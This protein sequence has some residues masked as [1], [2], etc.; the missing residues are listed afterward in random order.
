MESGKHVY[1]EKPLATS[2]AEARKVLEKAKEKNLLIGC[3]PDTFL[4]GG[5]QTCRKIIDDGL[6]GKPI[7]AVAFMAN[8]GHESWHPDPEFYYKRG[9]GPLLDMGPYYL[10]A[11][12]NLIGP[13]KK[14]SA[15]SRIFFPQRTITSKAKYGTTIK[16]ETPTHLAGTIDFSSGAI[17]TII[18]SF[19]VWKDNLPPIEIYGTK[20]SLC[21]TDPNG[22]GG[23]VRLF[24][25]GN[26]DWT[27]IPLYYGY[28]E[29]VRGIGVADMAYAIRY[30]RAHRANG[31]MA[32]HVLDVMLALEESSLLGKNREV[33]SSCEKPKALPLG[34][35]EGYLDE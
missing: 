22:F 6:I 5:L 3:A 8:H 26:E 24:K 14:V 4:G 1:V 25:A 2:R 12:V 32:Y 17:G 29:N 10:T 31:N 33:E 21:V 34:L 20:G 28:S 18:M 11:L 27:D 23:S 35:K 30:N 13:I 15:L 16:V 9:G 19:D 7:A